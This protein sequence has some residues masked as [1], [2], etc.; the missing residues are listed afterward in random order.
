VATATAGADA[1]AD[2][3]AVASAANEV[4]AAAPDGDPSVSTPAAAFDC[5]LFKKA[6][7]ANFAPLK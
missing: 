5:T 4:A 2:N 6:D 3:K 1:G 7:G